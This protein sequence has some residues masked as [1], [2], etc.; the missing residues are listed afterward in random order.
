MAARDILKNINLFADGR[1]YAGQ[2]QDITPPPL[3]LMTEEFRAGGMDA[4]LDLTMGM[5]K[6]VVGFNLR[7][8]DR[9]VLSLFGIRE[10]SNVPLTVRAALE[11]FDGT[12]KA[13]TMNMRVKITSI[14]PGTWTPGELGSLNVMSTASYFK[15]THDGV[16]IHE[17]DVENMVRIINGVD[18]LAD[19]RAALGI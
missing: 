11:S 18:A 15:Q 14:D 8:Y 17:I 2:L 13:V 19:I 5:E 10:G 12:V 1:G 7:A 4:P 16:V 3:T 9:D 6:M